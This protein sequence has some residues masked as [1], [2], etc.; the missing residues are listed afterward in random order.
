MLVRIT[1]I[2]AP[3][4]GT[5][6]DGYNVRCQRTRLTYLDGTAVTYQYYADGQLYQVL[7]RR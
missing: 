7:Q 6:H 1:S 4:T 3:E 2:T 5:I